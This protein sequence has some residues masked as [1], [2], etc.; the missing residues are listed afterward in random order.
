[1]QNIGAKVCTSSVLKSCSM[2]VTV[3]MSYLIWIVS[4]SLLLWI[5]VFELRLPEL[6][7]VK[8]ITVYYTLFTQIP[9]SGY[10]G[11]DCD[12]QAEYLSNYCH[13]LME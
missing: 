7:W 3:S 8:R 5:T 9:L 6:R 1:V 12:Y 11:K 2:D 4:S 13:G 10:H